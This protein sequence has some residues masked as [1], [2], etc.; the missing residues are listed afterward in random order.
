[1]VAVERILVSCAVALPLVLAACQPNPERVEEGETMPSS[2]FRDAYEALAASPSD[3]E[4]SRLLGEA[5][6]ASLQHGV[7]ATDYQLVEPLSELLT[8]AR[9]SMRAA[10]ARLLG[11]LVRTHRRANDSP[12]S[13]VE[14][15]AVAPQVEK[16]IAA[17]AA[18]FDDEDAAVRLAALQAVA[19]AD[20]PE[21]IDPLVERLDDSDPTVRLQALMRLH[22]LQ[23]ADGDGR[24]ADAVRELL[25]DP[26]P[27]VRTLAELIAA[28][29][30]I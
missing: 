1:M 11:F 12:L 16:A 20:D 15:A 3:T 10:S 13:D 23:D 14:R 25:D 29:S 27:Q 18:R 9:A 24:I 2:A 4:I 7:D 8:D 21:L 30:S 17:V 6:L 26:D 28:R 5:S 22:D 19:L